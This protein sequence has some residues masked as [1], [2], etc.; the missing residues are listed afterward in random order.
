MHDQA[1]VERER[2]LHDKIQ[3]RASEHYD[4]MNRDVARGQIGGI[5]KT[6]IQVKYLVWQMARIEVLYG[7]IRNVSDVVG[8]KPNGSGSTVV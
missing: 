8:G 2:D 5:P 3:K 1:N 6:Q 7:K 4:A